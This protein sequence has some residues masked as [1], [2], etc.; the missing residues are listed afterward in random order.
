MTN[1]PAYWL[2]GGALVVAGLAVF[3]TSAETPAPADGPASDS[4][5]AAPA[6][7]RIT[8]TATRTA[9]TAESLADRGHLWEPH[10]ATP[11]EAKRTSLPIPRDTF[12][13]LRH[14]T[15]GA[16]IR[17]KLSDRFPALEATVSH[18]AVHDDGTRVTHLRVAGDPV[19]ELIV[20]QNDAAGF[21]LA[22]LY[23]EDEPVAYEFRPSG[24]ELVVE[25]HPVSDLVCST[26]EKDGETIAMGLPKPEIA[27]ARGGGG[28]GG[29]GGGISVSIADAVV[30]E[31]TG[32]SNSIT[33]TLT[34]D[35]SDKR[36]DITVDY[37]TSDG[38]ATSPD[39]FT[40]V[41]GTVVFPKRTTER[42]ITIP[43]ATD[44]QVE[45]DETF[46]VTLSNPSGASLGTATATGTI[47]NDDQGPSITTANTVVYEGN[48]GTTTATFH[49]GLTVPSAT[50]VTV[51]YATADGTAFEPG[52]YQATSGTLTFLPGE[53]DK[54]VDVQVV[55]DTDYEDAE[56]FQ[57]VLSN[58]VG[59]P[60]GVNNVGCLIINDDA[61]P[62]NVPVLNSLPGATAVAYLD[63]DGETVSGTPW[64]G[65]NTITAGGIT[66]F[67]PTSL[68]HIWKHVAEDFAPF[69][70]NVTTDEAAYLAAPPA[71]RVRCVITPDNEWYG[72]Y[73]G[74]AYL[75]SFTWTGDTP[76]WVFSD[77]LS[78]HGD[79]IA[80]AAAHEIGHT[81]G[82]RHDGRTSPAENYYQGHGSGETGWAPIMGVGYY[83][84]LTQW[85]KGEYL[86]ADNPEDDLAII[87]GQNGFG[88]RADDHADSSGAATVLDRNGLFVHGE[89]LIETN[90]DVD[91]FE[92]TI[93]TA[94]P[95]G[96]LVQASYPSA[97]LDI[98]AEI[99][100]GSGN[101][102]ASDNHPD[103]LRSNPVVT[104]NPG[105][106]YL[107][108]SGTGKGDPQLDGYT[109][110]GSLG[111]YT[112]DGQTP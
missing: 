93:T 54:T 14:A 58:A 85:S 46:L 57:L 94:G 110:Y 102:L 80:E 27:E 7:E 24:D 70:I 68:T 60:I 78:N 95:V 4:A 41:S 107:H 37:A 76:C 38:S 77:M 81:L 100:D 89:G 69:E 91:V 50:T 96:I 15:P 16:S 3:L 35:S 55:G 44:S 98:L 61:A 43:I 82:L 111:P 67:G 31:G 101:L 22:Q 40:A 53:T 108:V 23:Y 13:P 56:V 59:A 48:S 84:W 32:G 103:I 75:N 104:L 36:N 90:G 8:E 79:Y 26:M 74:V 73:G 71:M 99:R 97:N 86:N 19:G 28:G 5:P 62:T 33:F 6:R 10:A 12:A 42:T 105:T 72:N 9:P 51:D 29:G 112:I 17:L 92:F 39:D 18:D 49:V 20:Q 30:N 25:R 52:D 34:L 11:R 88:Y 63:M 109:D 1:K 87:T 2:S 106:Y 65:G 64:N 45:G 47:V 83:R 21:F 66:S